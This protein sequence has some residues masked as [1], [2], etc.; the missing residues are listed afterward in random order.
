MGT[1]L[2]NSI[3]YMS[4]YFIQTNTPS[5][6]NYNTPKFPCGKFL[7]KRPFMYINIFWTVMPFFILIHSLKYNY[8][9]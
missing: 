3:L 7:L 8:L 4:E 5:S 2:M 6:I 1:Q 9:K